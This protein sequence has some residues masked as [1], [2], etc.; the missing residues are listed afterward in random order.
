ME[1]FLEY[2]EESEKIVRAVDHM[3][4]VTFPL[5][6]EKKLLIKIIVELKKAIIYCINSILQYEHIQNKIK[7]QKDT[8]SNFQIFLHQSSKRFDISREEIEKII[9]VLEIVESHNQSSMEF[10]KENKIIFLSENMQQSTLTLEKIK[11]FI[12][13]IKII[14]KKVKSKITSGY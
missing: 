10:V 12:I 6:K 2:L 13:T 3:T 14:I 4:Y 7:L 5:I 8:K 11:N 9:E 1:K